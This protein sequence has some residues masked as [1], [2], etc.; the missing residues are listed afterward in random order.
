M[1]NGQP[2]FFGSGS[3]EE[4]W[5]LPASLAATRQNTLHLTSTFHVTPVR[6]D[7]AEYLQRSPEGVPLLGRP[8]RIADLQIRDARTSHPTRGSQ[9]FKN[10]ANCGCAKPGEHAGVDKVGQRH[11]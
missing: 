7:K 3:D 2:G 6:L 5:N 8:C 11:A 10:R 9:R 4:V 1:K